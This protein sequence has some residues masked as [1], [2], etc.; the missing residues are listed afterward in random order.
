MSWSNSDLFSFREM[1]KRQT[2]EQANKMF[3]KAVKLEQDF[4]EYFTGWLLLFD[5]LLSV[6]INK[7]FKPFHV[8]FHTVIKLSEIT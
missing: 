2:Y 3:D 7:R 1:N 8:Y 4:G 6:V 5:F